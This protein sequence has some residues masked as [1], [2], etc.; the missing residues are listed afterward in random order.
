M[1]DPKPRRTLALAQ[2]A[3]LAGML[4]PMPVEEPRP[5]AIPNREP[6]LPRGRFSCAAVASPVTRAN[7]H[8]KETCTDTACKW[9]G[10]MLRKLARRAARPR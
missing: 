7:D 2:L 1:T 3:A 4:A 10:P 9:H 6:P 5:V 8:T